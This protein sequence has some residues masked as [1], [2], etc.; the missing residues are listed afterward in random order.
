MYLDAMRRI[1]SKKKN[2]KYVQRFTSLTRASVGDQLFSNIRHPRFIVR[3]SLA[4]TSCQLNIIP[5]SFSL[6]R[7]YFFAAPTEALSPTII[8]RVGKFIAR[9]ARNDRR[10]DAVE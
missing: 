5:L 9:R 3:G 10:T 1:L 8:S 4:P 2:K 7:H 6:I